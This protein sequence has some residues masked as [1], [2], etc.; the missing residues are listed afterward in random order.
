MDERK[1]EAETLSNL[2]MPTDRD[3]LLE[4]LDD[5]DSQNEARALDALEI[6]LLLDAVKQ[7]YGY[8]F[9][10]YAPASL[11]R[12]IREFRD[13]IGCEHIA[14]LIPRVLHDASV[15]AL[16]LRH[17]SVTV[18]E[19][20]RDPAFF[21]KLREEVIPW[22]KT[23]PF[24]KIWHA[25]CATGEEVYS[26]AILLDEAGILDRAQIYATDLN[27]ESLQIARRGIYHTE[28]LPLYE[29]NYMKSGGGEVLSNYYHQRYSSLKFHRRLSANMTFANHNLV[30]D[31]VFGEMHL[32]ICRNVLIY[33]NRN[34]KNRVFK[35][36]NDSLCPKGMLCLGTRESI[37]FSDIDTMYE[38]V[39]IYQKIY[40]KK[41]VAE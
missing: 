40:R 25:G 34:L 28:N 20:F 32:I 31:G 27:E 6:R 35:L 10:D 3:A 4:N 5:V 2:L 9:H 23:W 33:F 17:M 26:M 30:T 18:T 39:D 24:I 37:R 16:L 15:F 41:A 14:E 38:T 21:L 36:F 8:D 1:D 19:M 11:K 12:R 7:H 22:L 13:D 29:E